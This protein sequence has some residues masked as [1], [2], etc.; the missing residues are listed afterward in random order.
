[1]VVE[2]AASGVTILIASHESGTVE[3]LAGRAVTITGGRVTAQ[4]L[5]APRLPGP[6]TTPAAP[7]APDAGL[8]RPTTSGRVVHVA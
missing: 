7:E 1:M 2:A 3:G 8:D 5:L 6:A 4:R